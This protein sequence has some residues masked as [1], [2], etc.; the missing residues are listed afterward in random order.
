[1]RTIWKF[2]IYSYT[3]TVVEMPVGAVVVSVAQQDQKPT[4]WALVDPDAPTERRTFSVVGTGWTFTEAMRYVGTFHA[5]PFV[6]HVV[7]QVD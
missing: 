1:M 6:W 3:P 2:P 7:E 5:P 4:L